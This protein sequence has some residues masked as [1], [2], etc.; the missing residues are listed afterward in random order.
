MH[1]RDLPR[2]RDGALQF[3][4]SAADE[5]TSV[6]VG[7]AEWY[8]MLEQLDSF[9]FADQSGRS[10]T[11]RRER[12]DQQWYWYAYRKRGKQLRKIY[13]GKTD[14]LEADR[15]QAAARDLADLPCEAQ[16]I[17]S[18][19]PHP[20][21][22]AGPLSAEQVTDV[23]LRSTKLH[24]PTTPANLLPRPRLTQQ[25]RRPL[26]DAP[27]G[28]SPNQ[29]HSQSLLTVISAPAGYGKT[30]LLA[31]W[32]ATMRLEARD[33]SLE[34][35]KQASSLKPQAP[36]I[37]W[38]S[39]DPDDND[40]KQFWRYVVA[41]LQTSVPEVGRQALLLLQEPQPLAID[42]TVAALLDDLQHTPRAVVLVLDD[43][44]VI[45]TSAIHDSLAAL[46]THCPARAA[47]RDFQPHTAATAVRTPAPELRRHRASSRR[48]AS[49]R[50]GRARAVEPR[51]PPRR[52]RAGDHN[53][54][55]HDR[56][57][58]G[59]REPVC[60]GAAAPRRS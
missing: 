44:H 32:L 53:G 9:G 2:V 10:F 29:R 60:I 22:A 45:D 5:Q 30:T 36:K 51:A 34:D 55:A 6:L 21:P 39:L 56:W 1:Y 31:E 3:T 25:L 57:L 38:L 4:P 15:L 26:Q 48:A 40:I 19:A 41:A 58:A 16:S 33:L 23:F 18:T 8:H 11:A 28:M 59:R 54:S 27:A 50:R 47:C 35:G 42:D 13:L 24:I 17:S 7:S 37:A 49:D 46:L 52:Q 12:R 20:R 14:Q 43:Y